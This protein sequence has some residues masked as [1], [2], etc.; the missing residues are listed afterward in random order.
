[1]APCSKCDKNKPIVNRSKW[2]CDDCNYLRLHNGVS[3]AQVYQDRAKTRVEQKVPK[4]NKISTRQKYVNQQ[5]VKEK[6]IKEK[7]SALKL[8][9]EIEAQQDNHYYCW[10]CGKG[11]KGLDKSHILSVKQ[12]KD[13]EL[14]KTNIN[15]LCRDCHM[16]WEG[17]DIKEM[18]MLNCFE[19]DI[20]YIK[21]KDTGRYNKLIL[22]IQECAIELF[23]KFMDNRNSVPIELYQKVM[24]FE[25]KYDCVV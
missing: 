10:G 8:E 18:I 17:G 15:L 6:E 22:M 4:L 13:L 19:K 21:E 25:Q 3:R 2:L 9:I 7:L 24:Y 12:R 5:T 14:E 20:L 11:E 1:M 16:K 23:N